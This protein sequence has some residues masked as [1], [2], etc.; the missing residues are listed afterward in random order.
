MS[1]FFITGTDTGVGKT[2]VA[3]GLLHAVNAHGLRSAAMK[4]VAC[5]AVSTPHGPRNEDA[6]LLMQHAALRADYARVN[7]FLFE[8]PIAPHIAAHAARRRIDIALIKTEFL[9]LARAANCV[10]VEGVGGWQVPL[11]ERDSA[12]DLAAALELPVILV[13][14]MR[15]GCLNHALLSADAI[16][17]RGVSLAGWIAN[18]I[19]PAFA[20]LEQNITALAQ[21]IA[22]PLVG[23]V[24]YL[25]EFD[26]TAIAAALDVQKLLAQPTHQPV[27]PTRA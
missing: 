22:A 12:A 15:L 21:R 3:A 13:V 8:P 2:W 20:E 1:G 23:R 25:R 7:P 24:P 14:G 17:R 9:A 18:A 11:N 6:L 16:A 10:V 5:G 19:D 27:R 26:A 4:P